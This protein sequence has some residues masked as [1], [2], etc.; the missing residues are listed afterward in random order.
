M[1]DRLF[2]G[3][4]SDWF[5]PASWTPSGVPEAGDTMTVT[6]GTASITAADVMNNPTID[7]EQLWIGSSDSASPAGLSADG[8][9]FGPGFTIGST[10]DGYAALSFADSV[11]YAGE[12]DFATAQGSVSLGLDTLDLTGTIAVGNGDSLALS[13]GTL[14]LAG[15]MSVSDGLLSTGTTSLT[16]SGTI[17]VGNGG[18][19]AIDGAVAGATLAF[20]GSSGTID[21]QDPL[22]FDGTITGFV[23]GDTIDLVDSP[24]YSWT[25]NATTGILAVYGGNGSHTNPLVAQFALASNTSLSTL[26]IFVG[27]DG[28]GGSLILLAT[29]RT[30]AGGSGDWYDSSNWTTSDTLVANSYPLLGDTAIVSAGTAI[31]SAADFTTYGT[32]N[33]ETVLL[34]GNNASLDFIQGALGSDLT[35]SAAAYQTVTT[36][37]IGGSVS[38]QGTINVTGAGSTLDIAVAPDGTIA[39]DL[40]IGVDG[41]IVIGSEAALDLASGRVTN[42]GQILDS[43]AMTIAAGATLDGSGVID[44]E[45]TGL[46]LTVAGT[47]GAAQQV[48]MSYD[49][50]IVAQ[51]A[52]FAGVIEDFTNGS[53]IDLQGITADYVNYD[54]ATSQLIVRDGGANGA[55]VASLTVDGNYGPDDFALQSDGN[56]GVLVTDTIAEPTRT[57][58][59][60]LPEPAVLQPGQTISLADLLVQA[61]GTVALSLPNVAVSSQSAADMGYFSYWDPSDP[62]L[63]YWTLNGTVVTPD[64]L[65]TIPASEF[66]DVDYVAGNAIQANAEIQVPIAIDGGNSSGSTQY[67]IQ[68]FGSAFAQPSLDSGAPT[69]QDVVNAASAFAAAYTGVAN[70][71]DCWNIACEVAAAAG[72]TMPRNSYSTDPEHN[73]AGGFWRIAYAAPQTDAA[74]SNWST[75]VQAGDIL[76]IGWANGGPHSFTIVAPL[77][78]A[79]SITVFDNIYEADGYEAIGIHQANYWTTTNPNDITIYRLDPNSLYLVDTTEGNGTL[80]QN[81]PSASTLGTSFNDLI[82]P[83]GP[84]GTISCG[85]GTDTIADTSTILNGATIQG[86]GL[87][88]TLDFTDLV[89]SATSISYDAATGACDVTSGGTLAAALVLPTGLSGTFDINNDGGSAGLDGDTLGTI[90]SSLFTGQTA[91]GTAITFVTCFAEG[92]RMKTRHGDVRVEDLAIGDLVIC[93]DGTAQPIVWIGQRAVNVRKHPE[94]AKVLPV[95]IAPGAF[96]PGLPARPLFL[97]PDHAIFAEGVLIPVRYL[98]NGTTVRQQS[99]SRC[100]RVTYFHIELPEHNVILAEGLPVESYLDTGNRH[101]F[102]NGGG[103]VSLFPDFSPLIWDAKGYALL[104]VTGPAVDRVRAR[105]SPR[106]T[107]KSR[108]PAQ[109][110]S[111]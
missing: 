55:I 91:E 101:S 21:L 5:Q 94:P 80:V 63:P 42:D 54:T 13:G 14:D 72:A 56:G 8:A 27:S 93:A 36:I 74:I 23:T 103:L 46:T 98:V 10:G 53:T 40:A 19:V 2:Q 71:E 68:N 47:V 3:S 78:Q 17:T 15:A 7:G 51:G 79:G 88:D 57:F 35:L 52:S 89:Y 107:R 28:H 11:T 44:M 67:Y 24:A 37:A 18:T 95:R 49:E 99:V 34:S 73:V 77:N 104:V 22:N 92:T 60:T 29:P 39:G 43:G 106:K 105:L 109:R 26:Q 69:P 83:A 96:G 59:A 86:F 16:G 81:L 61:F 32:L 87:G 41:T 90:Y 85:G 111:V 110:M 102:S 31:I 25:Y 108:G 9:T 30:W 20:T 75:L 50:L 76:R 62:S 1:T 45:Y 58:Y 6:S 97:S 38:A 66:A 12:M 33:D 4:L 100:P 82:I 65:E 70:T 84:D 48:A 64:N